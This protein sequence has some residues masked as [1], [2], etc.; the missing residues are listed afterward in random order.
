[1]RESL[2][3]FAIAIIL[4]LSALLIGPY[5]VDWSGQRDWLAAKLSDA[6]GAKVRIAGPIDVKLLPRPIFRAGQISIDGH[7]PGEPRFSAERLD[8][9]LSIN[10]LLQGAVEFVDATVSSPRI[11]VTMRPD[12][13]IVASPFDVASPQQFQFKHVTIDN[14]SLVVVDEKGAERFALLDI[15]GE[16]EAETLFGP[17]KFSGSA[18]SGN[19]E[20]TIPFRLNTGAYGSRKL[21]VGL[22]LDGAGAWSHA[23]LDGQISFAAT[24]GDHEAT[25]SFGGNLSLAGALRVAEGASPVPWTIAA[26]GITADPQNFAAPTVELRAGADNRALVATG[27]VLASFGATPAGIVK[28]HARQLDLDRITVPPE[29]APDTPRPRAAQWLA[30][31]RRVFDG[32]LPLSLTLD[33]GIDA[34]TTGDLTLTDAALTLESRSGMKPHVASSIAGPDGTRVAFDGFLD[35]GSDSSFKGRAD[36]ATR[37]LA[38]VAGWV[39]PFLSGSEDWVARGGLGGRAFT[40]KGPVDLSSVAIAAHDAALTLGGS[41]FTGEASFKAGTGTARPRFSADLQADALD[42]GQWP[43]W[44]NLAALVDPID[45]S[46]GLRSDAVRLGRSDLAS[47]PARLSLH[48]TKD[49]QAVTLDTLD[50]SGFGGATVRATASLD[51]DKRLRTSGRAAA[52]DFGP[53]STFVQQL[54]P[55]AI[56]DALVGRAKPLS[57]V[58]VQFTGEATLNDA[59]GFTP[60][61]LT[62]DGTA[63]GT[64]F[65]IRIAPQ[66]RGGGAGVDASLTLDAPEVSQV[67][68]QAGFSIPGPLGQLHADA[69]GHGSLADGFDGTIKASVPSAKLSFDG[70]LGNDGGQGHLTAEGSDAGLLLRALGV[71]RSSSVG[72]WNAATAVSLSDASIGAQ[73]IAARI[74]GSQITGNLSYAR[75]TGSV[76]PAGPTLTGALTVDT[77]SLASLTGLALAPVLPTSGAQSAAWSTGAFGPMPAWPTSEIGLKIGTVDL[78]PGLTAR[79]TAGTLG[80]RPGSVMLGGLSGHL[81]GG[82][83]GG[84]LTLRRNGPG[85]SATGQLSFDGLRFDLPSLAGRL[86]GTLTLAGT[87]PSPAGLVGSLGGD[88]TLKISGATTPRLNSAALGDAAKAFNPEDAA[89][90]EGPVRETLEKL[91]DRSSLAL[92][93]LSGPATLAAGTLRM[94][95]LKS[96]LPDATVTSEASLDIEALTFALRTTLVATALPKD[97]KGDPPQITVNWTGPLA[98]PTRS[99]DTA[100]FVNGLAARA[101]QREQD[102]IELMKDD[103]RERA[104]FARRLKQIEAE[105]QAARDAVL[106]QKMVPQPPRPGDI[107]LP[108]PPDVEAPTIRPADAA[109]VAPDPIKSLIEGLQSK[110]APRPPSK[111]LDLTPALRRNPVPLPPVLNQDPPQ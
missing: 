77:A 107:R 98:S 51:A 31:I 71:A 21:R 4:V 23:V 2:T 17:V 7:G 110:Q 55:G 63:A 33:A 48:L 57:P 53:L 1:M 47:E 65:G 68:A 46:I 25:L 26:A 66:L 97:W 39:D 94:S 102:R 83:A 24:P 9:E 92:G 104:F 37:D 8:A 50:L 89:I 61:S 79:E 45:V 69:Q 18:R 88:G 109:A 100:T 111:P 86:S 73:G 14:G 15:A 101:I 81:L 80:L 75:E 96:S 62:G 49:G 60:V 91:L 10:G 67:L 16:G 22:F 32:P 58:D 64:R 103:L 72:V 19:G 90:D 106:I 54:A 44:R 108:K 74:G 6:V 41:V 5:L 56:A 52:A 85:A 20:G 78:W 70:R 82:T 38:T 13:A 42:P 29:V 11:Q 43:D 34:V 12:G 27:G 76:S 59:T 105:Q 93:D 30:A 84:T 36:I 35:T 95:A 99:I 28:L 40:F 87:G 3:I